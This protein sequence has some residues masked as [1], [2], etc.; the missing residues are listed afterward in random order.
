MNRKQMK[1]VIH[2]FA[3]TLSLAVILNP[4]SY[5]EAKPQG[6]TGNT[7]ST[8]C[9]HITIPITANSR[10][11]TP[12]ST[13]KTCIAKIIPITICNKMYNVALC[14]GK[15]NGCKGIQR[16]I[17]VTFPTCCKGNDTTSVSLPYDCS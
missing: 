7:N 17:I 3:V 8:T 14:K 6:P 1:L 15:K 10:G 12:T 13:R 11:Y 9:N 16:K 5:V 2:I 4:T